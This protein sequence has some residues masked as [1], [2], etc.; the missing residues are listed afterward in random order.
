[1]LIVT[2]DQREALALADRVAVMRAGQIVQVGAAQEVFR[3]PKTAW[4][5]EFLG[6]QNI[7][8]QAGG[9]ALL[10]PEEALV[11]GAGD[12]C[13]VVTAVDLDQYLRVGAR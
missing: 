13:P 3:E 9:T 11:L 4:V 10:V 1:M 8:P 5:A 6:W 12:P 2:H 7:L